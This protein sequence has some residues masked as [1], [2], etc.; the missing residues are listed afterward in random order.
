MPKYRYGCDYCGRH[1][2]EW[3]SV[4]DKLDLCPCCKIGVPKKLPTSFTVI[5]EETRAKK[6]S[7][8]NVVEHIEENREILKKMRGKAANEDVL[9][10]D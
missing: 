1:W 8:Q 5:E 4:A 6:T 7:K 3:G 9:K 10:N 2:W